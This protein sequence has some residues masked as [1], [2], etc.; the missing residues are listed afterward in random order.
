MSDASTLA[1]I[2]VSRLFPPDQRAFL[3]RLNRTS[4]PLTEGLLHTGF[5][6]RARSD[7]AA[8]AVRCGE[9]VLSYGELHALSR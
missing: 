8:E 9:T 2:P 1:E 6:R 3:A 7:P 5:E 4:S